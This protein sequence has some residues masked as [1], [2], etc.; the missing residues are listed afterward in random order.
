MAFGLGVA[1]FV[2]PSLH[3]GLG[4]PFGIAL[5][6]GGLGVYHITVNAPVAIAPAAPAPQPVPREAP[7]TYQP[8]ALPL[9]S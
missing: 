8:P 4:T 9:G 2:V 7:P 3:T 1:S 6:V 5:I